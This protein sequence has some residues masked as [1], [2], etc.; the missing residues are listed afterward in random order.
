MSFE[1]QKWSENVPEVIS[2]GLKFKKFLGGGWPCRILLI[3][4]CK[5]I[6]L[7]QLGSC[8]VT[9]PFLSL[10]RVW[11]V[12]LKCT[13]CIHYQDRLC[14]AWNYNPAFI[15][16]AT[17]LRTSSFKDHAILYS[18]ECCSSE[19]AS[20]AMLRSML[21]F[22]RQMCK[23]CV[24]S[25]LKIFD[26]VRTLGHNNFWMLSGALLATPTNSNAHVACRFKGHWDAH[27]AYTANMYT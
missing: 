8:S 18:E 19:R 6:P 16:G 17:N 12:R 27:K 21:W 25:I 14:G 10:W 1:N 3:P 9:R 13:M 26:Y 20:A 4:N 24:Q 7:R 11:L 22:Q 5:C 23:F 2:E 15:T